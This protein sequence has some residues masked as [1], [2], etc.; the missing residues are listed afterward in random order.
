MTTIPNAGAAYH[1]G[2]SKQDYETPPE[3]LNAVTHRFGPINCD[4]AARKDNTKGQNW[5]DI[6]RDSLT[7]K[8]HEYRGNCWLNPPFDNITP[9]AKKCA[10]E[11]QKGA[12][13]LFLTPASVGA[14]WFCN[15]VFEKAHV[16]F[17]NGR[18]R[19]V[20]AKDFYPKDCILS[21]FGI[22]A[23]GFSVWKWNSKPA[24]QNLI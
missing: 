23:P 6:S 7:V 5:I 8:W 21:V 22:D 9:W 1:R 4:L 24:A 14:N 3:F 10:D 13:I 11:S 18:I 20:G 16:I 19:F 17:L 15:Y 12:Q 2:A